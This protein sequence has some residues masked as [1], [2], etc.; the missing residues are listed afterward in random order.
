MKEE[1]IS[2][3]KIKV[4][5]EI[6]YISQVWGTYKPGQL[7]ETKMNIRKVGKRGMKQKK[8]TQNQIKGN[9]RSS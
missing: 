4:G 6:K 8:K 7:K 2:A 5:N 3:N 9:I 1:Q